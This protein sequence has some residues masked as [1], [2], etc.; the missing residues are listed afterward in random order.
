MALD[1]GAPPLQSDAF[2]IE[3]GVVG[4]NSDVFGSNSDV[5]EVVLS[6][7]GAGA[8][9]AAAGVC[10]TWRARVDDDA[11][12]RAAHARRWWHAPAAG[13]AAGRAAYGARVLREQAVLRCLVG[14]TSR[15][16]EALLAPET[17]ASVGGDE[18]LELLCAV[19]ALVGDAFC[20]GQFERAPSR[21]LRP[22]PKRHREA[23]LAFLREAFFDA[24]AP[25]AATTLAA[26]AACA[27]PRV[28]AALALALARRAA[29]LFD[30][31][32]L[33]G[34]ATGEYAEVPG[35]LRRGEDS[36]DAM[37]RLSDAVLPRCGGGESDDD[38]EEPRCAVSLLP[39]DA[40]LFAI[41]A[42]LRV[43]FDAAGAELELRALARAAQRSARKLRDASGEDE[44]LCLLRG[45]AALFS[46]AEDQP[47]TGVPG[48][49]SGAAGVLGGA[50][51]ADV[52]D[53]VGNSGDYYDARNSLLDFVLARRAGIPI[54]LATV[55]VAV[56]ERAGVR[57]GA[58]APVHARGHFL[59]RYA[60]RRGA[61][62]YVDAF[63]GAALLSA[64][65]ATALLL[66]H[67]GAAGAAAARDAA[68]ALRPAPSLRAADGAAREVWCRAL[69]NLA[70]IYD[71]DGGADAGALF[72]ACSLQEA[73]GAGAGAAAAHVAAARLQA[74]LA[75]R[76]GSRAGADAIVALSALR[77]DVAVLRGAPRLPRDL[78]FLVYQATTLTLEPET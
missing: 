37:L 1:V 25:A 36:S 73:A 74:T 20:L 55:F 75:L 56:A 66:R 8:R 23:L 65:A 64:A 41:T 54:S 14:G 72:V 18:A 53:F 44:E 34:D 21:A 27:A 5:F 2:R 15:Q 50:G 57:R 62:L 49:R 58:V 26:A 77:R 40:G 9:C 68:D 63:D 32:A 42:G 29:A 28:R 69:R 46:R 67:G 11:W 35:A 30:P 38:S 76:D 59:L 16:L 17:G 7:C 6:I 52:R 24:D 61:A 71:S 51:G 22:P 78:W 12:W 13:I 47:A 33:R 48:G 70:A 39:M 60:A 3:S 45:A 10:R 31:A 19:G 43:Y 4:S